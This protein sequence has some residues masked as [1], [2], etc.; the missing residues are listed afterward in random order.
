MQP[1]FGIVPIEL[2]CKL[3]CTIFSKLHKLFGNVLMRPFVCITWS[4]ESEK[5]LRGFIS[6]LSP[7][8]FLY[9][10]CSRSVL[11]S[12]ISQ[13]DFTPQTQHSSSTWHGVTLQ[14]LQCSAQYALRVPFTEGVHLKYWQCSVSKQTSRIRIQ[15]YKLA[16]WGQWRRYACKINS[17]IGL[18]R[19]RLKK[20]NTNMKITV[21]YKLRGHFQFVWI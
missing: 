9:S 12:P 14:S 7:N 8:A 17:S 11:S 15:K 1:K 4:T 20:L 3:M 21:W 19:E 2:E 10:T 18:D 5:G 16:I 13:G 6:V